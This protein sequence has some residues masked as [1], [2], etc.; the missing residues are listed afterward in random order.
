MIFGDDEVVH[1]AGVGRLE[2]FEPRDHA[3]GVDGPKERA[4]VSG[5]AAL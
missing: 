5:P 4:G 3:R 1:H 2:P